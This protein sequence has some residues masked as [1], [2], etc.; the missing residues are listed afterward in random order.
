M[1]G[2][3]K[4]RRRANR[5]AACMGPAVLCFLCFTLLCRRVDGPLTLAKAGAAG[6][7]SGAA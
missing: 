4:Y 3:Y 7:E 2:C 5:P 6:G 1:M